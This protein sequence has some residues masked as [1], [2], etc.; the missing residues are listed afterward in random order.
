MEGEATV[1]S[2]IT[3]ITTYAHTSVSSVHSENEKEL[4][5]CSRVRQH[6]RAV[7]GRAGEAVTTPPSTDQPRSLLQGR[8]YLVPYHQQE[9]C[10]ATSLLL[11]IS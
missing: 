10:L 3:S 1:I 6:P 4:Q 8:D 7:T 2:R 11:L 5:I 9:G